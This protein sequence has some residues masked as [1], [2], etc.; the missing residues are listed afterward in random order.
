M[1][2][3]NYIQYKYTTKNGDGIKHVSEEKTIPGEGGR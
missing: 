1:D 3:E 2:P